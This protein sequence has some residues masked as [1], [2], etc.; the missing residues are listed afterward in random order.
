MKLPLTAKGACPFCERSITDAEGRRVRPLDIEFE[1]RSAE[2]DRQVA[3]RIGTG[4]LWVAGISCLSF[5]PPAVLIT[6][7]ALVLFQLIYARL[8]VVAPYR[9]HFGTT[10]RM[11]TRW[12]SRFGMASG[13]GFHLPIA[14]GIPVNLVLAPLLFAV[15]CGLLWGYHRW[16]LQRE[17]E[18]LPVMIFEKVLLWVAAVVFI[19]AV[20]TVVGL[21]ML[22]D[23]IVG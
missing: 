20:A 12:I 10:R 2:L 13:A 23:T 3:R 9:R 4:C 16:H 11:V 1:A 8:A 18:H 22:L 19:L 7:P 5:F 17:H 6:G 15:L 21:I 14:L